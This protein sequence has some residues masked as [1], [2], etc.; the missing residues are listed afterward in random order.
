MIYPTKKKAPH[1]TV[2][3]SDRSHVIDK[4]RLYRCKGMAGTAA[5]HIFCNE[6]S[7]C[8]KEN[9]AEP[10]GG[11]IVKSQ[12]ISVYKMFS[13]RISS[14]NGNRLRRPNYT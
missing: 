12:K 6:V 11:H 13:S 8:V 1:R 10:S 5:L 4:F 3:I 9:W 7:K 2:Q 14:S